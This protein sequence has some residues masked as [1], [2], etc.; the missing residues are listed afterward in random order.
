M[1][2]GVEKSVHSLHGTRVR[3][4]TLKL[5]FCINGFLCINCSPSIVYSFNHQHLQP[6]HLIALTTSSGQSVPSPF[7]IALKLINFYWWNI[8][9][10]SPNQPKPIDWSSSIPNPAYSTWFR[11]IIWS[12]W[13]HGYTFGTQYQIITCN[14]SHQ[15][16][17]LLECIFSLQSLFSLIIFTSSYK[18][19]KKNESSKLMHA[20]PQICLWLSSTIQ[21]LSQIWLAMLFGV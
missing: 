10:P 20:A 13:I 18:Q 7:P 1:K 2:G 12:S 3:T 19:I 16:W 14:A 4:L 21:L 9:F 8:F 5:R 6:Y 17:R 11:Q 15:L